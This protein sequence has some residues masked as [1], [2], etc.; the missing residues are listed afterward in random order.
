MNDS[1]ESRQPEAHPHQHDA[2]AI[3]LGTIPDFQS[4]HWIVWMVMSGCV[5]LAR[6]KNAPQ[7]ELPG[8]ENVLVIG[9]FGPAELR[10]R[11]RDLRGAVSDTLLRQCGGFESTGNGKLVT[12]CVCERWKTILAMTRQSCGFERAYAHLVAD[13]SRAAKEIQFK[14]VAPVT[15]DVNGEVVSVRHYE[16]WRTWVRIILDRD[17]VQARVLP[18]GNLRVE[19]KSLRDAGCLV[20]RMYL[21]DVELANREFELSGTDSEFLMLSHCDEVLRTASSEVEGKYLTASRRDE[22]VRNAAKAICEQSPEDLYLQFRGVVN[23]LSRSRDSQEF[24]RQIRLIRHQIWDA[25]AITPWAK[26]QLRGLTSDKKQLKRL[27]T[28]AKLLESERRALLEEA[29]AEETDLI[30]REWR[31]KTLLKIRKVGDAT[32]EASVMGWRHGNATIPLERF[33]TM[34]R[35]ELRQGLLLSATARLSVTAAK[36]L[37]VRDIDVALAQTVPVGDG[38]PCPGG[39]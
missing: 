15:D 5:P 32:I 21:G 10:E 7:I 23:W 14:L 17:V 6:H 34:L 16:V 29:D 20:A 38:E 19:V 11:L 8:E 9:D 18:L 4:Q 39:E 13:N 2:A 37:D 25:K 22:I 24:A 30:A 31:S 27:A 3:N 12:D 28:E 26:E 1:T 36:E 33:P 35:R